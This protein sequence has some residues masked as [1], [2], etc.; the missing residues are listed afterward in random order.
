M[1]DRNGVIKE[2][3]IEE[4]GLSGLDDPAARKHESRRI[5]LSNSR[6]PLLD[7]RSAAPGQNFFQTIK[8]KW[9]NLLRD[10]RALQCTMGF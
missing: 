6:V 2:K 4:L 9:R 5:C 3:T 8:S 10:Q 1:E 7:D